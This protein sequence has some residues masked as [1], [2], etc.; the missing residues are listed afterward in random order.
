MD[1]YKQVDMERAKALQ[2]SGLFLH[3]IHLLGRHLLSAF[4]LTT[5][6]ARRLQRAEGTCWFLYYMKLA[7]VKEGLN[8]F[9]C[10][11][12]CMDLDVFSCGVEKAALM[13][14]V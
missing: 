10:S 2:P 8:S 4:L 1:F 9:G 14:L 12:R 13:F 7:C 6:L 3:I 5:Y 11:C